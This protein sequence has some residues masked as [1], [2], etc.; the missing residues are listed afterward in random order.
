MCGGKND[1]PLSILRQEPQTILLLF[2]ILNW[3][4]HNVFIL[5]STVVM[6][7]ACEKF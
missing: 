4:L 5:M 1:I 3:S 2:L 6:S 7:N